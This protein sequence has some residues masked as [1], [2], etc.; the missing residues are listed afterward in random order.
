MPFRIGSAP[1]GLHPLLRSGTPIRAGHGC[2]RASAL[3]AQHCAAR[4]SN[5]NRE[6]KRCDW[7]S[8]EYSN[9]RYRNMRWSL[10]RQASNPWAVAASATQSACGSLANARGVSRNIL[11]DIW[12]STITEASAVCASASRGTGGFHAS[13]ENPPECLRQMSGPSRTISSARSVRTKTSK[14]PKPGHL[15]GRR[16]SRDPPRFTHQLDVRLMSAR[17]SNSRHGCVANIPVIG[18]WLPCSVDIIPC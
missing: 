7:R 14:R 8:S 9:G 6:L 15:W 17:P 5:L 11:R 10:V 4:P 18:S 16:R 2:F 1:F 12:S 3:C 13:R